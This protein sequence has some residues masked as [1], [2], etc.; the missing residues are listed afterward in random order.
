[1]T[2][3]AQSDLSAWARVDQGATRFVEAPY[4]L[5][6]GRPDASVLGL[7][8]RMCVDCAVF[9]RR[10]GLGLEGLWEEALEFAE[11]RPEAGVQVRETRGPVLLPWLGL[12]RMAS[13]IPMNGSMYG[14]TRSGGPSFTHLAIHAHR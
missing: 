7:D 13:V 8:D 10:V 1:M 11:E 6:L 2:E 3:V 5:Q 4:D 14:S 12:A 9:Y